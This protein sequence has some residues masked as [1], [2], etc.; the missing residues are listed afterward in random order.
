MAAAGR[1]IHH[2]VAACSERAQAY[3]IARELAQRCFPK[4]S[5]NEAQE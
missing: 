5:K 1:D 4:G 3:H 2:A